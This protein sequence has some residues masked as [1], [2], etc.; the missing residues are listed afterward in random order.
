MSEE[1]KEQKMVSIPAEQLTS[2]LEKLEKLETGMGNSLKPKRS[3]EHTATL[4]ELNGKL[5][6][7]LVKV[8]QILNKATQKM[9]DK[10]D[11]NLRNGEKIEK[12][13]M[14][15]LDYLNDAPKVKVK[16]LE[17]KAENVAPVNEGTINM[18]NSKDDRMFLDKTVDMEV[19]YCEYVSKVEVLEGDSKGEIFKIDN[20]FLND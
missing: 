11:L 9:E 18:V 12:V 14:D 8:Y 4:R 3:T 10:V 6:I 13:T 16:L 15:Y 20:K 17:Q 19:T 5:V 7:G 2:I 1:K